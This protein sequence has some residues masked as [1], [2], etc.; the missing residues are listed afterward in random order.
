[1]PYGGVSLSDEAIGDEIW[2]PPSLQ[3]FGRA[4]RRL[5]KFVPNRGQLL[6]TCRGFLA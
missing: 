3:S 2:N 4:G 5:S 6:E 1:M